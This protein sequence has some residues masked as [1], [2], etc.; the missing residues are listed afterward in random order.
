MRRHS[1]DTRARC[2]VALMAGES[3]NALAKRTGVPKAT[4][5]RW[6]AEAPAMLGW[7]D[8]LFR[9]VCAALRPLPTT[10]QQIHAIRQA[11]REAARREAKR[12]G[13][14]TG[15]P[16]DPGAQLA[17]VARGVDP[18]RLAAYLGALARAG[19]AALAQK[20]RNR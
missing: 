5:S 16:A 13:C 12:R 11:R 14:Q 17:A 15:L 1:V 10:P 7:P 9:M 3:V 6:R 19:D 18:Q 2:T 20:P 8:R 4:L